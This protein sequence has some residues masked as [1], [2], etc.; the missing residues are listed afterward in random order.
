[1]TP[2]VSKFLS[3]SQSVS[4]SLS[5]SGAHRE[6]ALKITTWRTPYSERS[7]FDAAA[8]PAK[9]AHTKDCAHAQVAGGA[10]L[11]IPR[12]LIPPRAIGVSVLGFI[13]LRLDEGL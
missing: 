4:A 7:R 9:G 12:L 10:H 6:T 5:L 11:R 8:S 1:M 3:L 13:R 2:S